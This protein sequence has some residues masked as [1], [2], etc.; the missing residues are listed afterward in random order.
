MVTLIIIAVLVYGS[1]CLFAG[2]KWGKSAVD[3]AKSIEQKAG[4]IVQDTRNKVADKIAGK[5]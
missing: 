4:Q 3:K 2:Y 1:A 5:N